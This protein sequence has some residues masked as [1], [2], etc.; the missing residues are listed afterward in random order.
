MLK[1]LLIR[2]RAATATRNY[3]ADRPF[4]LGTVDCAH[5]CA[6]ALVQLGY[7]DPLEGTRNYTTIKGAV[8]ALR[9]VGVSTFEEKLDRMGFERIAPAYVLHCDI[10]TLPGD[11]DKLPTLG[12]SLGQDLVLAFDRQGR[13]AVGPITVAKVAWRVPPAPDWQPA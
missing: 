11:D 3:F 9:S 6:Y 7:S 2:E 5:L 10:V 8:R 12:I 4:K 1:S 13:A